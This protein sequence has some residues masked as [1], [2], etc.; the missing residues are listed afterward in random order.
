MNQANISNLVSK[1]NIFVRPKARRLKNPAGP[2]GRL[3]KLRKTV[4]ALIKYE[5]LELNFNRGEEARGYA[6]R[7]ISEALR[8]GP[9]HHETMKLADFWILE[10]QYVHKLFKVLV[11]R[12]ENFTSSYTKMYNAPRLYP[13]MYYKKSVLELKGNVY[14]SLHQEYS[15][16]RNLLHNVLLDEARKE[17]RLKKYDEIVDNFKQ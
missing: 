1:L 2:E 16:K 14:P 3:L 5:R 15:Q 11:P 6:E 9:T 17:F 12:Y 10:K 7:L 13:G 8:H 4:T